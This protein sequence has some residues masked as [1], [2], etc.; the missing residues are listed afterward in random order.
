MY[1]I[2]LKWIWNY[3][4]PLCAIRTGFLNFFNQFKNFF[5]KGSRRL[6]QNNIWNVFVDEIAAYAEHWYECHSLS[7]IFHYTKHQVVRRPTF[8][9]NK[10]LNN[11]IKE[12]CR[13]TLKDSTLVFNIKVFDPPNQQIITSGLFYDIHSGCLRIYTFVWED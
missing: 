8:Y 5:L 3:L 6:A 11:G 9:L 4:N 7:G 10:H 1:N 12:Y 2:A 13:K